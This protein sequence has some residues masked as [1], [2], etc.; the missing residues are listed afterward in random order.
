MTQKRKSKHLRS[1]PTEQ[2]ITSYF[3]SRSSNGEATRFHYGSFNREPPSL[4]GFLI[5]RC[6][7]PPIN[8]FIS[9]AL[10]C[11]ESVLVFRKTSSSCKR[12]RTRLVFLIVCVRR[13]RAKKKKKERRMG[14]HTGFFF[15]SS[16]CIS[17][18]GFSHLGVS[19]DSFH[20]FNTAGGMS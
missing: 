2:P 5:G 11:Y 4:P 3:N 12:C 19:A 16:Y 15:C 8:A 18:V 14:N 7:P 17:A 6:P 9:L 20:S 13:I 1:A 10:L